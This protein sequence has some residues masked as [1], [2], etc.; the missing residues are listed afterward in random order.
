MNPIRRSTR[1]PSIRTCQVV[2]TRHQRRLLPHV[3][4][5]QRLP[6]AGNNASSISQGGTPGGHLDGL[7]HGLDHVPAN[8]LCHVGRRQPMSRTTTFV[9]A[10][11]I[12][13]STNC[14][15][16]PDSSMTSV[17]CSNPDRAQTRTSRPPTSCDESSGGP[18]SLRRR[19]DKWGYRR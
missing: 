16:P 14:L 13:P 15:T 10:P 19:H 18:R 12:P 2:Q 6:K 17:L 11:E 5:S 9:R 8:F 7:H 1:K 4:P 3:L